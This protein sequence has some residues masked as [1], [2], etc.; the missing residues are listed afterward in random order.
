M[1]VNVN[2]PKYIMAFNE[3][4]TNVLLNELQLI[5]LFTDLC[6]LFTQ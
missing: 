3:I 4:N 1:R 6:F 5:R 2:I